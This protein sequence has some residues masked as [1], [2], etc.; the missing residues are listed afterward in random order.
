M[1]I[2]PPLPIAPAS[3]ELVIPLSTP[4]RS[5]PS[6]EILSTTLSIILPAFP[7]P[8]VL[9]IICAPLVR[10]RLVVSMRISPPLPTAPKLTELAIILLSL[11]LP[12]P[13]KKMVSVAL[14]TMLPAFPVP[15]VLL[16]ICAPLVK[17]RLVVSMRTSPPLPTAFG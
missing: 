9:P 16:L 12:S 11:F 13:S 14:I 8:E 4:A 17:L 1:R 7:I 2:S 5:S 15:K 6:R 3:T 10:L